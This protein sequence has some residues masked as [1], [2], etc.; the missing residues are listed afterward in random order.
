MSILMRPAR[1]RFVLAAAAALPGCAGGFGSTATAERGVAYGPEPWRRADVYRPQTSSPHAPWIVFFHGGAWQMG[2]RD[3]LENQ[4]A[5]RALADAGCT[6]VVPT[7]RLHGDAPFPGFMDDAAA[8]T[9][10]TTR[11]A[12]A[13]TGRPSVFA[14]GHSAGAWM[15]VMLA[16][17]RR[18]LRDGPAEGTLAGAIGIAGPYDAGF[19]DDLRVRPVFA[20]ASDRAALVA[21]SHARPGLPPLRLLAGGLDTVVSSAQATRLAASVRAAGGDASARVFP[22]LGHLDIVATP[23][24]AMPT[25]VRDDIL[26]FVAGGTTRVASR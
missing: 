15:A 4:V 26:G 12:A 24:L 6:V 8:A 23:L 19:T 21:A 7:Y 13:G 3:D 9:H 16:L 5:A 25:A 17:D 1:R 10:W 11:Q 2:S 18:W 20:P 14:A 22:L